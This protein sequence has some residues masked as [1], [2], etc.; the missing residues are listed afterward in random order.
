MKKIRGTKKAPLEVSKKILIGSWIAAI[1]LT[2]IVIIGSFFNLPISDVTTL[3]CLAWGELTAAHAFYYWKAKNE[4]RSKGV[5]QLV[6]E[7]A[8][9]YGIDGVSRIAEIIFKD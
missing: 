8:C 2:L 5:C 3:A 9:E 7:L 4:N 6:R 1:L